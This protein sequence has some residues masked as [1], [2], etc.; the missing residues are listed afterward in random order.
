MNSFDVIKRPILTEKSNLLASTT[1]Y[2]FEVDLRATKVDVKSAVEKLFKVK[3]MSV[4]TSI[5][6][7]KVKRTNS[8]I[9]TTSK[10]KKAT[11]RLSEGTIELFDKA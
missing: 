5:R 1:S 10:T 7:R 11:V 8:G 3:V 2:L 4:N 6:P 9:G